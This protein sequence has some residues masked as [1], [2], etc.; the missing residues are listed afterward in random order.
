MVEMESVEDLV[1][2]DLK[3]MLDH[4]DPGVYLEREA[5]M[6]FLEEEEVLETKVHLDNLDQEDHLELGDH[7]DLKVYLGPLVQEDK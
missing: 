3:E 4:K 1:V 2:L 7:Q 6:V 5:P